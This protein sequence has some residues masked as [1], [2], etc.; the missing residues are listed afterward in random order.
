MFTGAELVNDVSG[1]ALDPIDGV[2]PP[3]VVVDHMMRVLPS[4]FGTDGA[5]AARFRRGA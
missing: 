3:D 2:V 1:G 4:Q 5:F